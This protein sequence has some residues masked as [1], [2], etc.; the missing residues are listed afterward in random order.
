MAD[1]PE[2]NFRLPVMPMGSPAQI[3]GSQVEGDDQ[4]LK[5]SRSIPSSSTLYC[6]KLTLSNFCYF[7]N[8]YVTISTHTVMYSGFKSELCHYIG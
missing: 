5:L 6:T 3:T 4:I 2:C 1:L 8:F 7:M